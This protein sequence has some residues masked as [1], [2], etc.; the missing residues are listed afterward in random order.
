M[1]KCML[2]VSLYEVRK[3]AEIMILHAHECQNFKG[4]EVISTKEWTVVILV[5]ATEVM[6]GRVMKGWEL[7]ILFI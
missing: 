4:I 6:A 2:P 3:V 1:K 7:A 5:G